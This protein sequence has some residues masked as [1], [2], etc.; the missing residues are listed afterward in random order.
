GHDARGSLPR[1]PSRFRWLVV[2][3]GSQRDLGR[4]PGFGR[5]PRRVERRRQ[6]RWRRLARVAGPRLRRDL[7][8]Q[9]GD[10]LLD[11]GALRVAEVLRLAQV[12][13]VAE[14]RLVVLAVALEAARLVVDVIGV[15]GLAVEIDKDLDA[16]VDVTGEARLARLA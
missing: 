15:P 9:I 3:R 16:A 6:Q 10:R 11:L 12:V 13:L 4:F 1:P 8:A 7:Q 14:Q 2:R 5:R